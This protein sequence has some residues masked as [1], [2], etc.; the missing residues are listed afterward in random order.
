MSRIAQIWRHPIKGI[1]AEPLESAVLSPNLPLPGDRAWALLT[2]DNSDTGTWQ[3]CRVFARGCYGPQLM[4]ITARTLDDGQIALSHPQAG[5]LTVNPARD[6]AALAAWLAP[7][8]PATRPALGAL[9]AAPEEGMS[10][11]PYGCLSILGRA[12]LGA[13]SEACGTPLDQRRF[14]GNVWISGLE[15]WEE[16]D[17][18]GRRIRL[19]DVELEVVE[20]IT[21]CRA[22]QVNPE[23]GDE[24]VQ[25]L[26][27]LRRTW[28]HVDFGV[29]AKVLSP[30]TIASGAPL[31]VLQ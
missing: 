6:G 26:R 12:S 2:G 31:E 16:L 9:I 8:W 28:G 21:R 3:P 7:L 14:R 24:D 20:R 5:E 4:A 10:D 11:A 18:P 19:G 25:T 15:P 29:K 30:G 17:W 23:T 1:G 27:T 22:T 13:L